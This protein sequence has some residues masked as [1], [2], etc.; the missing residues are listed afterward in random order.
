[1]TN[2]SKGFHPYSQCP[3]TPF[4][5][6]SRPSQPQVIPRL[7]SPSTS[8]NSEPSPSQQSSSSSVKVGQSD[9]DIIAAYLQLRGTPHNP[10][11]LDGSDNRLPQCG[12]CKQYGHIKQDCDTP[13]RSFLFCEVCKG[14]AP[15]K[16]TVLIST[17]LR[18]LSRPSEAISPMTKTLEIQKTQITVDKPQ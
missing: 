7:S 6:P 12:R 3:L 10:I 18:S 16:I 11:I 8:H 17:C 4:H 9:D 13:L 5:R 15:L 1:M 14:N 2:K